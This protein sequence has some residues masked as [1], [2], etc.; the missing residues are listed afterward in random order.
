MIV[1][2]NIIS[3]VNIFDNELLFI[4]FEKV[5]VLLMDYKDILFIG[6]GDIGYN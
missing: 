3:K 2:D 4:E 6:D 1:Y 5:K